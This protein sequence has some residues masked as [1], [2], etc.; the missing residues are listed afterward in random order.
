[1][2]PHNYIF[3][4][5]GEILA[6]EGKHY[7]QNWVGGNIWIGDFE[8]KSQFDGFIQDVHKVEGDLILDRQRRSLPYATYVAYKSVGV[9]LE[10]G[11]DLSAAPGFLSAICYYHDY[12]DEIR[13]ALEISEPQLASVLYYKGLYVEAFATLELLLSDFLLCG[14]FTREDYYQNAIRFLKISEFSKVESIEKAIIKR[15]AKY[16]FHRFEKIRDMYNA[17]LDIWLPSTVELEILLHKRH[18]IVHRF[19]ISNLDGMTNR[20]LTVGDVNYLIDE[21]NRFVDDLYAKVL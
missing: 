16:V 8:C 12:I 15:V 14:V 6:V 3:E 7:A 20:D 21:C 18:N 1:M 13:K 19:G 11:V 9:K 4:V 2:I 5:S 17:I 10:K